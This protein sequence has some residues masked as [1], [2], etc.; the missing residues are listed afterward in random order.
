MPLQQCNEIVSPLMQWPRSQCPAGM[1]CAPPSVTK[2]DYGVCTC[3]YTSDLMQDKSDGT[4][5]WT[6]GSLILIACWV[7]LAIG[8]MIICVWMACVIHYARKGKVLRFNLLTISLLGAMIGTA[9]L[10]INCIARI[11]MIIT[12]SSVGYERFRKL[13]LACELCVESCVVFGFGLTSRLLYNTLLNVLHLPW[14]ELAERSRSIK[15]IF[16]MLLL[17]G[18]CAIARIVFQHRP[19]GLML[20]LVLTFCIW[21]IFRRAK[22]KMHDDI[23]FHLLRQSEQMVGDVVAQ[24]VRTFMQRYFEI[25]VLV[26]ISMA[27]MAVGWYSQRLIANLLV[28]RVFSAIGDIFMYSLCDLAFTATAIA[29]TQVTHYRIQAYS[30]MQAIAILV[31]GSNSPRQLQP[32]FAS[33]TSGATIAT[34]AVSTSLTRSIQSGGAKSGSTDDVA[35]A[36]VEGLQVV[37]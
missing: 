19:L 17:T 25:L 16:I 28:F 35:I 2:L 22:S 12:S 10:F 37:I 8:A 15:L 29:L 34:R 3:A 5:E 33:Q 7:A 14:N 27:F 31:S 26:A 1:F 23:G 32:L 4:C 11:F 13:S 21:L 18:I 6:V 36:Q 30:N 20:G 9:G 24:A